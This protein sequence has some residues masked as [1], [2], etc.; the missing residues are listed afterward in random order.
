MI[1]FG[2]RWGSRIR[3][4]LSLICAGPYPSA[5]NTVIA[6]KARLTSAM[7]ELFAQLPPAISA[8]RRKPSSEA[9]T[10]APR[11]PIR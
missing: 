11:S 7:F 1:W 2:C 4:I 10:A 5:G 6:V 8:A 9:S 3:R